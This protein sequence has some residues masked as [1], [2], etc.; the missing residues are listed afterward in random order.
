MIIYF[1]PDC[2]RCNQ[3]VDLLKQNNC[4]FTIRNYLTHPPSVE[5]L[6]EL[7]QKLKCKPIDVVRKT[8]SLYQEKYATT[9]LTDEVWLQILSRHPILIERPIVINHTNAIIGRPPQLILN[10]L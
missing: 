2:S 3:A 5:E 6:K 9:Q 1:N 4:E 8:E 7:L 10:I